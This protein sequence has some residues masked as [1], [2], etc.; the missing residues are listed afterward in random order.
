MD[1]RGEEDLG[2]V[3][4]SSSMPKHQNNCI[5]RNA[6]VDKRVL[7]DI[8]SIQDTKYTKFESLSMYANSYSS[9]MS[10]DASP[11][12]HLPNGF[13]KLPDGTAVMDPFFQ[14]HVRYSLLLFIKN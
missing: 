7:S 5:Y 4:R 3:F 2:T 8:A 14:S 9:T 13:E 12:R 11:L 10:P 1:S 6:T